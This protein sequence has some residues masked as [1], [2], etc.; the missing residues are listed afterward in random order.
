MFFRDFCQWLSL[1]QGASSLSCDLKIIFPWKVSTY[2]TESC[3][4]RN[5]LETD[6]SNTGSI[7]CAAVAWVP[8]YTGK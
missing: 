8:Q 3:G 1:K 7:C 4:S 6:V 2:V 5:P